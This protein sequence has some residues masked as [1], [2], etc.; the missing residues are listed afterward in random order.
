MA[1]Y[2]RTFTS[3]KALLDSER[4][5]KITTYGII[6][7]ITYTGVVAFKNKYDIIQLNRHDHNVTQNQ[8]M[9]VLNVSRPVNSDGDYLYL[10]G[11]WF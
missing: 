6:A 1:N 2:Y 3:E 9:K 5:A 11:A 7:L 8:Q 10:S 4:Y